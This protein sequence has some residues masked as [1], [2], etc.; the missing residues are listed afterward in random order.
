MY[1]QKVE[2]VFVKGYLDDE[3]FKGSAGLCLN[4]EGSKP[5]LMKKPYPP[6]Q[7]TSHGC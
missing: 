7:Q 5:C 6:P 4:N 2:G 3:I 1:I